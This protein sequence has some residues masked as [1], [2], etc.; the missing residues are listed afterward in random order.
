MKL[1]VTGATGFI[2]KNLLELLSHSR[3]EIKLLIPCGGSEKTKSLFGN[4][5]FDSLEIIHTDDWKSIKE[6]NPELVIHIAGFS[7]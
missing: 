2:G 4:L 7:N 3:K 1:M 5:E 6:F